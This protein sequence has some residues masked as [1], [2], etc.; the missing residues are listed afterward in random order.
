MIEM[1][2]ILSRKYDTNV[3]HFIKMSTQDTRGH[4][5]K[6]FK[7]FSKLNVR[8]YSFLHTCINYWNNLPKTVVDSPSVCSFERRLD[9]LWANEPAKY[10]YE[11]TI[12]V[13]PEKQCDL[14]GED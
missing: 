1:Y 8:K 7:S 13:K 9:K 2:K 10:N 12:P 4:Q 14:T 5:Y 3:T 6:I 11:F